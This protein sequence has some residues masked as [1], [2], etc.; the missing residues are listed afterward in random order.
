VGIEELTRG[1]EDRRAKKWGRKIGNLS[2]EVHLSGR[3]SGNH[4]AKMK[5]MERA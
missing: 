5:E 2:K 4:E 1:G 3:N